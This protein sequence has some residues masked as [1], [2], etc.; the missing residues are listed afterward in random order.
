VFWIVRQENFKMIRIKNVRIVMPFV[1]IVKELLS[2]V[3]NVKKKDFGRK[4]IALLIVERIIIL[5][6]KLILAINVI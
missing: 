2:T 3:H 5:I 4:K 1:L 6:L